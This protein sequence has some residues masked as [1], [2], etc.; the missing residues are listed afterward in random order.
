MCNG[1]KRAKITTVGLKNKILFKQGPF[2]S[3]FYDDL[4]QVEFSF[5]FFGDSDF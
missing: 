1:G 4:E 5:T 3:G 2:E